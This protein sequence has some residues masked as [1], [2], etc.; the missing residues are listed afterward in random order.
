MSVSC[1]PECSGH[2][3]PPGEAKRGPLV[4]SKCMNLVIAQQAPE[5]RPSASAEWWAPHPWKAGWWHEGSRSKHSLGRIWG[6]RE[7]D[8]HFDSVFSRTSRMV[9]FKDLKGEAALHGRVSSSPH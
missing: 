3:V 1:L 9:A 6:L 7:S 5:F 4:Y 2:L 8:D